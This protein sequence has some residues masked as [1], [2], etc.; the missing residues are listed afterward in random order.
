[1]SGLIELRNRYNAYAIQEG[2]QG[3]QPLPFEQFVRQQT[4][5]P[6]QPA[7]AMSQQQFAGGQR[8]A[9]QAQLLQLLRARGDIK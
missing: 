4:Q 1:M 9:N 6:Q 2:E 5:A 3:R 7:Q 8:P